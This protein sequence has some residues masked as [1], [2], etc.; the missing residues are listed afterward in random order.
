MNQDQLYTAKYKLV[1]TLI[2]R[3]QDLVEISDDPN[4]LNDTIFR[5]KQHLTYI[6]DGCASFSYL[7]HQE[8]EKLFRDL[9]RGAA[10]HI[11]ET[12]TKHASVTC[13]AWH[14]LLP[15]GYTEV[16]VKGNQIVII[17]SVINPLH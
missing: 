3:K 10:N 16:V 1:N 4:S 9:S 17:I 6:N 11:Y 8:S 12:L 5:E 14:E 13:R 7:L 15:C 2:K